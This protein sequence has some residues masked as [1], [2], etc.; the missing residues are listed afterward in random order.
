MM[1]LMSRLR[2]SLAL[3]LCPELSSEEAHQLDVLVRNPATSEVAGPAIC[4]RMR[5]D[6]S[7]FS[8]VAPDDFSGALGQQYPVTEP[9]AW[10][11]LHAQA[12]A[13][14]WLAAASEAELREMAE[15]LLA[16]HPLSHEEVAHQQPIVLALC[17]SEALWRRVIEAEDQEK[18]QKFRWRPQAV[19][20]GNQT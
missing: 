9:R 13:E 4:T 14:A 18:H 6:Y 20:Q 16:G 2:R 1:R 11:C 7:N 5:A 3:F 15:Q 17:A 10:E 19:V 8:Q 12:Q